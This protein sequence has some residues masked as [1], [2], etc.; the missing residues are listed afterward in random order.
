MTNL[1]IVQ[2]YIVKYKLQEHS[3][4]QHLVYMRYYL[5]NVLYKD[6]MGLSA[7]GRVFNRTHA[8]IYNGLKKHDDYLSYKDKVYI[9]YT[10][11][12]SSKFVKKQ[13]IKPLKDMVLELSSME[14]VEYLQTMIT[15]NYL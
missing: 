15:N 6:G 4:Y 5:Y 12:L 3:K 11:D 1:E 13:K 14:Q 8:T 2:E 9:L 7:I 10:A